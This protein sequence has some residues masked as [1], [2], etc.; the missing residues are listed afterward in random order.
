M[1]FYK[2][3]Y[4]GLRIKRWVF[5]LA[6]GIVLVSMGFVVTMIESQETVGSFF[7]VGGILAV[8]ISV[9]KILK[10]VIMLLAPNQEG[11]LINIMYHRVVLA[12]GTRVVAIGGGTGLSALLHGLKERTSN[13]TAIVTVAD[14]GGSSGRLR[15]QYGVLPPG[16]IRNC[17]VALADSETL[18]QELFQF[19]FKEGVSESDKESANDLAGHSFG[20]LF[21]LAMT[22]I[23]GDFEKAVRESSRI[24]N[25][26]GRVVPSTLSAV[27]LVAHHADGRVTDGETNI[28]A[29]KSPIEKIFLKPEAVQ[30]ADDAIQAIRTADVIVLGP[31][32]LYTSVLPNLLIENLLAEIIASRAP[33]VYVCNIM[34][35]PNETSHLNSDFRH[36]EALI[37]N[38]QPE[39]LTHVIVNNGRVPQTLTERYTHEGAFPLMRESEKI[40]E[41]GYKV[42]EADL[43]RGVDVVRHNSRRL[44]KII[45]EIAQKKNI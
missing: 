16:D 44:A 33:K 43:I 20:N 1:G 13:I 24:L 42:V 5:L 18:M 7:V 19:R 31:G 25:I 34:T 6:V 21:I 28:S 37:K 45:T 41:L 22:K 8:I 2:W 17:L 30:A 29:C 32:S 14:D 10:S 4:P 36:V 38:T 15:N 26:R 39:V 3:L 23:T 35:Q 9:R 11:Q 40:R 12:S 27:T